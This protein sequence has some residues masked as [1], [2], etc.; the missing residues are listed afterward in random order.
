MKLN[1]L[2]AVLQ[3]VKANATKGKTEVYQL[4]QKNGLFQGLSRTY[5]SREEDGFIYPPESQKLTLK[6]NDLVDKFALACS[7]FWDLAA[8]QDYANTGSQ[9]MGKS[10]SRMCPYPICYSSK[11][12]SK[13]SRHSSVRSQYYRSIKI[14]NAIPIGAVMSLHP[15]KL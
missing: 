1:Q 14:G 2:I 8:T 11:S 10:S 7:E 3:T 9:S 6:A 12:S 5:Q 4:C 13:I 15:K